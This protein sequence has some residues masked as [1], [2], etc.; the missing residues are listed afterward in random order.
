MLQTIGS[1]R[2]AALLALLAPAVILVSCSD[3]GSTSAQTDAEARLDGGSAQDGQSSL[4]AHPAAD[5][6]RMNDATSLVDADH[7]V[8]AGQKE[9]AIV[10]DALPAADALSSSDAALSIDADARAGDGTMAAVGPAPVLLGAAG[11]FVV[12]AETAITNVPTSA[13]TG[14]VGISPAAASYV[15]GFS[16]TRA[17]ADW[18][19][20]QVTGA[21][22]A[23][24]NDPPTPINLTTAIGAMQAAYTDAAS[25]TS[26]GFLNLGG[27][28]IGGL[29]LTPGLYKWS[30]DVTVSADV[31]LA[32][33]ADDVWIFQVTGALATSAG[34]N[35]TL[36]GGA[37]AKN[38]FWQVAGN[39][40][41]GATSRSEGVFL[42]E[43]E[44]TL[45]TGAVVDGRLLAQTA[46][47]LAA[48]TVTAP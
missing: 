7:L 2:V 13:I 10:P 6:G 3:A 16:M 43:T 48:S 30:S 19:S 9:D 47:H 23:A 14:N 15:T 21:L 34:K 46:V 36:S 32:G 41:L 29:T 27:G 20:S 4:D 39:V 45:E 33:G 26:P 5:T 12:L 1:S 31:I 24:D 25:R 38:V 35:M 40:D 22:F 44:I 42:C 11:D 18:T 17:G 37:Q 28:A 8:E